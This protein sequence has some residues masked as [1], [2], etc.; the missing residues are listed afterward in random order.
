MESVRGVGGGGGGGE[1]SEIR[2]PVQAR[3]GKVWRSIVTYVGRATTVVVI[4]GVKSKAVTVTGRDKA[5]QGKTR[6]SRC[7]TPTCS[8][9]SLCLQGSWAGWLID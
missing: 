9:L 3:Q 8:V 2:V 1:G 7:H 6:T 5:R 4:A